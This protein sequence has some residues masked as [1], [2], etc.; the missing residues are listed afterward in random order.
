MTDILA[1]LLLSALPWLARREVVGP[2]ITPLPA[3]TSRSLAGPIGPDQ[4]P[5]PY[6][7]I[8]ACLSPVMATHTRMA[9][10]YQPDTHLATI[11]QRA[12]KL[13]YRR[14]SR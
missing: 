3:V 6:P 7:G 1:L 10:V 2:S 14:A 5:T 8:A 4:V 11:Y 9:R 12:G 13:V